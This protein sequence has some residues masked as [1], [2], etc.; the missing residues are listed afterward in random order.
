MNN[1]EQKALTVGD[2]I[3]ILQ[4]YDSN[5]P[6]VI[7]NAGK[8]HQYGLYEEDISITDS[9]YFGNDGRA[10]EQFGDKEEFLNL[11]FC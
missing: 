5:I 7:T 10:G 6:L 8:D 1:N 4:Q 3:T 2:L 11:G 9:A